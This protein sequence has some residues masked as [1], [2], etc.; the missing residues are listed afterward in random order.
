[1][2]IELLDYVVTVAQGGE[3]IPVVQDVHHDLESF[4][5]TF[6]YAVVVR[7]AQNLSKDFAS[8]KDMDKSDLKKIRDKWLMSVEELFPHNNHSAIY[9][10]RNIYAT[11]KTRSSAA[12]LAQGLDNQVIAETWNGLRRLV[13]RQNLEEGQVFLTYDSILTF[14]QGKFVEA[15]ATEALAALEALAIE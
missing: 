7:R 4:V 11:D 5:W 8:S 15:Q 1:M 14:L 3:A 12:R 2:A 9:N 10:A 13:Y 6:L